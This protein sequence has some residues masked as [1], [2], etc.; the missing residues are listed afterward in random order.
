M[1]TLKYTN[2]REWARCK[3]MKSWRHSLQY[4]INNIVWFWNSVDVQS[5]DS[6]W[7][8]IVYFHIRGSF[9]NN[10]PPS[11]WKRVHTSK[12]IVYLQGLFVLT[13]G[14]V[15]MKTYPLTKYY[16]IRVFYIAF[17]LTIQKRS[18]FEPGNTICSYAPDSKF[19]RASPESCFRN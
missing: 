18:R 11:F 10:F 6:S 4:S 3:T 14:Y 9:F 12:E 7:N 2:K 19:S 13:V 8:Y 15:D 1:T 16:Y 5:T 17:V